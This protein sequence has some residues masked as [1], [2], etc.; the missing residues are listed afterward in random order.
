MKFSEIYKKGYGKPDTTDILEGGLCVDIKDKRAYSKAE[1]GE[2]FPLGV[3]LEEVLEALGTVQSVV[4]IGGIIAYA[5]QI[6]AIPA[7]WTICNGSNGTPDLRDRFIYGTN[8]QSE[9]NTQGG[10]KVSALQSHSHGVNGHTHTANTDTAPDHVHTGIM[11]YVNV[12]D[13]T[14]DAEIGYDDVNVQSSYLAQTQP[15]G[16]HAHT[17]TVSTT[18]SSLTG[19][20]NIGDQ[21]EGN[22]PPYVKLA[23]IM[24]ES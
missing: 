16:S 24:R 22:L 7:S 21:E 10:S 9:I 20:V 17:V 3:S 18:P 23:Y 15:A 11:R 1:D 5:G 4:P 6:S 13:P 19:V 12:G 8:I 14:A 2:V